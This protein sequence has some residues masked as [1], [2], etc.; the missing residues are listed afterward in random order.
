MIGIYMQEK[1]YW[2]ITTVHRTTG[3]SPGMHVTNF[4]KMIV[5][6]SKLGQKKLERCG[7]GR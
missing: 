4:E 6:K 5:K 2:L 1:C 3:M 7:S